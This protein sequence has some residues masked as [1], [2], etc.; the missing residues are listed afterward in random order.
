MS[1][2][3][4]IWCDACP[5]IM[6]PPRGCDMSPTSMPGHPASARRVR[7]QAFEEP[8]QIGMPPV[9]SREIRMTCQVSPLTGQRLGRRPGS[10]GSKSRSSAP[11][12][13]RARSPDR[14]IPSRASRDRRDAQAAA[15]ALDRPLPFSCA[16]AER[17]K[18]KRDRQ[19][20][21]EAQALGDRSLVRDRISST[22]ISVR[23]L[24]RHPELRC[25]I[26]CFSLSS[27]GAC[28]A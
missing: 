23:T 22:F 18:R 25:S 14:T 10:R 11:R 12:D 13:P 19:R 20:R 7:G 2:S 28:H 8:D 1:A 9:R 4:P 21:D 15:A 3:R 17:L 6:G 16:R 27:L 5:V 24:L 26:S